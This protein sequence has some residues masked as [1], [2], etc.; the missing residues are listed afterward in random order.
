MP[1]IKEN[2]L[3]YFFKTVNIEL[4]N[5]K[6]NKYDEKFD[7]LKKIIMPTKPINS[8][9][10][11][12][13]DKL[14]KM[15]KIII[16][17]NKIMEDIKNKKT[18]EE[19]NEAEKDIISLIK[20]RLTDETI[21][22]NFRTTGEGLLDKL[23]KM[24]KIIIEDNKIMEDIKNK[25]T[26]EKYNEVQKEIIR[27]IKL[28]D[29]VLTDKT[30]KQIH[31]LRMSIRAEGISKLINPKRSLHTVTIAPASMDQ[32]TQR[33]WTPRPN[34]RF[35]VRGSPPSRRSF[36]EFVVTRGGK[37]NT[38]KYKNKKT[39]RRKREKSRR[40]RRYRRRSRD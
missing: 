32:S 27:R 1:N 26:N 11:G 3:E 31:T 16:E 40:I 33:S 21:N 13:L 35:T 38:K 17:D 8:N 12:L 25:K 6:D 15:G 10:E 34:S 30:K 36:P 7:L 9:C 29:S 19:Y 20:S 22:A 24:G 18:N 14:Y 23:Y 28:N 37:R 5:K 4:S 39:K 2:G